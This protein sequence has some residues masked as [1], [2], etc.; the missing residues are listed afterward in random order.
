MASKLM[1]FFFEFAAD[2]RKLQEGLKGAHADADNMGDKLQQTDV[3]AVSLGENFTKLA[4]AAGGAL[5]AMFALHEIKKIT[6]ETADHTYEVYKSAKAMGMNVEVLSAWQHAVVASGGSA[7]EATGSLSGLRDKF[8]EMSRFGGIMGP[9]AVQFQ[10]LGLSMKDMH[11]SAKDP[12]IA[13]GKLADTFGRLNNTQQLFIGKKLGLDMG[14]ISLLSLGR[15][16]M[17]EMIAKQKELG[18]VTEA[19]ALAAAKFK[20]Q[21]E[22]LA[23]VFENVKREITSALLPAWT[24][25]M[26]GIQKSIEFFRN[27]KTFA[28]TFFG[29]IA[30]VITAAFLPA[31]IESTIAMGGFAIATLA[32]TWPFILIAAA[33]LLAIAAIAI[34]TEDIVAFNKG[35]NSL[36]GDMVKKWPMLGAIFKQLGENFKLSMELLRAWWQIMVM[37]AKICTEGILSVFGAVKTVGEAFS[38]MKEEVIK[39]IDKLVDKF[40]FL[41]K[42][43][44]MMKEGIK[45][46]MSPMIALFEGAYWVVKKL[47]DLLTKAPVAILNWVGRNLA[48]ATGGN[49]TDI[50]DSEGPKPEEEKKPVPTAPQTPIGTSESSKTPSVTVPASVGTSTPAVPEKTLT[51]ADRAA[52]AASM[53]ISGGVPPEIRSAAEKAEAKYGVPAAITIAQWKLESGSGKHMPTGSN[54]P[55]GIKARAG[56]A[57]VEAMTTEHLNGQD[58]R[59]PQKFRKFDSIDQAFDEH[60]KLLAKGSAYKEARKHTDDVNAYADALTGHYATDPEYGTKLKRIMAKDS[61][62]A[63]A[64]KEHQAVA[65]AQTPAQ[66]TVGGSATAGTATAIFATNQGKSET[67]QGK[68]ATAGGTAIATKEGNTPESIAKAIAGGEAVAGKEMPITA[69]QP[70]IANLEPPKLDQA[71]IQTNTL[72]VKTKEN[73]TRKENEFASSN[74]TNIYRE[75]ASSDSVRNQQY[76]ERLKETI[77]QQQTIPMMEMAKT[78]IGQ[79]NS[80]SVNTTNSQTIAN[81]AT[82]FNSRN[83]QR[84]DTNLHVGPV[85]VHTNATNADEIASQFTQSL[86]NHFKNAADQFDDAVAI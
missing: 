6:Q 34:I 31:I 53:T 61:M 8:V 83:I 42:A 3:V 57:S 5:A 40:P 54:N 32:A 16:G 41:A 36:I 14:T 28:V 47:W 66:A 60:A 50:G 23:L 86:N 2:A 9:E 56:E 25:L 63:P 76:V 39:A 65:T 62:N 67:N 7:E 22:Q 27:H 78:Q 82:T 10:E 77:A 59:I 38:H 46:A 73:D 26:E 45:G 81:N 18:V 52:R 71:Y 21:Q 79:A 58:V 13:M 37:L 43:A 20:I 33:V 24:W 80:A 19:Q 35:Q 68:V 15:R 48:K 17:E 72:N 44:Q 55:F 11:D 85:A 74:F 49:Y 84:G 64:E 70:A 4:K 75:F 30:A 12:T 69:P 29:G 1:T 51:G